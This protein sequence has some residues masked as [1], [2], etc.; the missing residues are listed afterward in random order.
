MLGGNGY[1]Y[2]QRLKFIRRFSPPY[3]KELGLLMGVS[4]KTAD[5]VCS[6]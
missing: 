1:L 4:E 2:G 6:V 3:Q 5:V